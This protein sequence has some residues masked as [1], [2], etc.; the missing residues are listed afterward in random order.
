MRRFLLLVVVLLLA[1]AGLGY[2]LHGTPPA[3]ATTVLLDGV[4]LDSGSQDVPPK[5]TLT[6]IVARGAQASDY[7]ASIDGREVPV[8]AQTGGAA[9]LLPA[10]PQASWH[11]LSVWREGAAGAHIS[12]NEVA[13]RPPEPL[14]LAAAWLVAP[15][16]AR[17]DV[18]SSRPLADPAAVESALRGA[19]ASVN[20]DEATISG[21]WPSAAAGA[22]LGFSLPLGL[23]ST[24]GS[25][26]PATFSP[27]LTLP[28][29]RPYSDV[30]VSGAAPAGFSG[31][32]LQAY[33]VGTPIG[34]ADLAAHAAQ[35]DVLTPDFYGLGADGSLS[36]QV[37]QAALSIAA[38]GGIEGQPPGTHLDFD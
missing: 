2:A 12:P 4:P 1:G 20:V 15:G 34:R 13:F 36:S 24:S 33:Y 6:V 28:Q 7:R 3:G 29:A 31:L 27:S 37:D 9:L 22:R 32:K 23:A 16:S 21:S 8:E 11:H 19:G 18:S 30:Q 35:I 17:V 10:M 26:L 25:Y 5:P 14:R 38:T